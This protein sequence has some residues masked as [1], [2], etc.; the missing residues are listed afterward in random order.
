MVNSVFPNF[1]PKKNVA[2]FF[3]VK[4]TVFF[5]INA[6]YKTNKVKFLLE[7]DN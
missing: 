1:W 7:I 5:M 6:Y 2:H 3:I 4:Y